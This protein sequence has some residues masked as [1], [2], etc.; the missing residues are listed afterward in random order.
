M[1]QLVVRNLENSVKERIRQRARRHRR[2]MEDEVREILRSSVNEDDSRADGLGTEI[3]ALFDKGG[4][5]SDIPELLG[6]SLKPPRFE[7]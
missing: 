1:A 4:L 2:S 6:H 3:A 7:E 5:E